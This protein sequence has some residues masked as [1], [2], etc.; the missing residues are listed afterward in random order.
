MRAVHSHGCC[1]RRNIVYAASFQTDTDTLAYDEV[2]MLLPDSIL[3]N[4]Y[5]IT[6]S[7]IARGGYGA[8]YLAHDQRLA[9]NV[10]L[11]ETLQD[12]DDFLRQFEHEARLLASLTHPVLPHVSDYFTEHQKSY[13]VMNH[14]AG[15]TLGDYI[16]RQETDGVS[17]DVALKLLL[18]ILGALV[19]LHSQ[20]PPVIHRDIKP[21][22]IR[23]TP[24]ERVYLV[25]FGIARVLEPGQNTTLAAQAVTQGYSPLEQYGRGSHTDER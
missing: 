17:L 15:E 9:V 2:A 14:I 5:I 24:E 16:K 8:V 6:G 20:T 7:P 18:P 13:L 10:A 22:N 21:A 23:I 11:K 4:R 19:Y 3:Q 25:D 12:S 1:A